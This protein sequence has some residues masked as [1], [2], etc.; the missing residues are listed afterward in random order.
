VVEWK[1]GDQIQGK[2]PG[3]NRWYNGRISKLNDDHTYNIKYDDGDVSQSFKSDR[4][5]ARHSGG[6]GG[7]AAASVGGAQCLSTQHRCGGSCVN[8][9]EDNN[10]CGG[11]GNH[12][13][14]NK[15]CDGH[16]FCRDA[17]GDL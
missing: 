7:G 12:C 1:V 17:N 8:L 9:L 10:N 6:G 11:C 16:G 13:N 4:V 5:R 2:W 3:D 14:N 15:H